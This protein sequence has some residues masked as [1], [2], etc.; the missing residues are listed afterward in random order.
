MS[1]HSSLTILLLGAAALGWAQPMVTVGQVG[2]LIPAGT[3]VACTLDEPN[4]NS[5]TA[6]AG[7]PVL[8]KTAPVQMFGRTLIPRGA[9]LGARLR[10]FRDPGHFVGK[11]WLQLEFTTLNL[12]GGAI[13]VDA[14][15]ISAGRYKVN[16][17][18]K[19]EGTGHPTR[20]AIEWAIPILWPIKVLT[21]PARGPRPTLKGETRIE[22]RVMEDV[23]IPDAAYSL[24]ANGLPTRPAGLQPRPDDRAIRRY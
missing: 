1:K 5:Q 23:V 9:Y 4:F 20:D 19:V 10:N 14:K 12:P 7:D 16:G 18:G 15:V 8:C 6:R 17:D 11:G 24:A 13:P 3:L 22:L 21:L 2:N